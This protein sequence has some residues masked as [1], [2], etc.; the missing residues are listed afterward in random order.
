MIYV[1]IQVVDWSDKSY[2]LI[3]LG[4]IK[5]YKSHTFWKVDLI[6]NPVTGQQPCDLNF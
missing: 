5:S 3:I 2:I 1:C 6:I 4:H